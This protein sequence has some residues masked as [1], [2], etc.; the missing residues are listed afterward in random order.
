MRISND[1]KATDKILNSTILFVSIVSETVSI[2]T[3]CTI[4]HEIDLSD[5]TREDINQKYSSLLDGF[6]LEIDANKIFTDS[7]RYRG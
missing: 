7:I 2:I 1:L 5:K 4:A 6:V 3:S